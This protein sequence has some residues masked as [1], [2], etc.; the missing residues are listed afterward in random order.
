[1][2]RRPRLIPAVEVATTPRT[3][4][5]LIGQWLAPEWGGPVRVGAELPSP[6]GSRV[7][8]ANHVPDVRAGDS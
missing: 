4:G 7:A 1:M 3:R 5:G 6:L 2:E 8:E